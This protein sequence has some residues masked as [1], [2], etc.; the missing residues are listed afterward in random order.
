MKELALAEIA[1]VLGS[2]KVPDHAKSARDACVKALVLA[3][4]QCRTEVRV[5]TRGDYR[6]GFVDIE[7]RKYGLEVGIEVDN[8]NP[9]TKS[10]VK[11][12][13]RPWLKVIATRGKPSITVREVD[14]HV[15]LKVLQ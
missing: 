12:Q 6:A 14:L 8:R 1:S 15:A 5:A 2:I 11:L 4:W 13:C 3:G 9:R 7:A 10:A